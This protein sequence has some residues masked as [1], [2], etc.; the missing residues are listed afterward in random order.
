MVTLNKQTRLVMLKHLNQSTSL[1]SKLNALAASQAYIAMR[2]AP[3]FIGVDLFKQDY[4]V[5]ASTAR[6]MANYRTRGTR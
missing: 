6:A 1:I 5:Q 3:D 2:K 4:E